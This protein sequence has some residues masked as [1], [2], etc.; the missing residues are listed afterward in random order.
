[1]ATWQPLKKD[2]IDALAAE[3]LQNYA[4]GRIA[5]DGDPGSGQRDLAD[6]LAA[7]L[8][9]AGRTVTVAGANRDFDTDLLLVAGERLQVPE[10]AGKWRYA[11]W[12]D[13]AGEPDESYDREVKPRAKANAIIDNRDPGHPRRRFA[14]SC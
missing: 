4:T 12:V 14:D 13:G 5:I 3:I 6:D 9:D 2:V 8:R 1:M 7:S 11:V 10:L